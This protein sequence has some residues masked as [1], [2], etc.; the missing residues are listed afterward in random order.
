MKSNKNKIV[1][2]DEQLRS[3][4]DELDCGLDVYLN[5]ETL[6]TISIPDFDRQ[7]YA[8]EEVWEDVQKEISE[9][10]DKAIKFT[11]MDSYK[12]YRIMEDFVDTLKD[13]RLQNLLW[14]K[15]SMRKPFHNF[16]YEID[17]SDYREEWFAF[18][19]Q[20][21]IKYVKLQLEVSQSE[22]DFYEMEED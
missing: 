9:I 5:T 18:K 8:E 4:A 10:E 22:D 7:A 12:A 11:P 19:L 13:K 2:S 1:L 20:A 6:E 3:I 15:L 21:Y 16:S 17:R 14:K